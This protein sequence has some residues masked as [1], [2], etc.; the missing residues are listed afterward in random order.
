MKFG[1][2]PIISKEPVHVK[3]EHIKGKR[4]CSF[5][6]DQIECHDSM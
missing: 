1:K 2:Y 6:R 5:S 4:K 3:V